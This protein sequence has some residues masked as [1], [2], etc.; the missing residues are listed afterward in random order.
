MLNQLLTLELGRQMNR[1]TVAKAERHHR[2][3]RRPLPAEP[4]TV[5]AVMTLPAP[6]TQFAPNSVRVA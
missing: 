6:R 1:E 5:C 2:L 3:F 4:V